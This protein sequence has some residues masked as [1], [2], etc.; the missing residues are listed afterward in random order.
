MTQ[1][2]TQSNLDRLRTIKE[3]EDRNFGLARTP[4]TLHKA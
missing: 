2:Y 3:N 1:Q 4:V